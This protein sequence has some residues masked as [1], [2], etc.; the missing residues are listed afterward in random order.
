M[1]PASRLPRAVCFLLSP[2]PHL[3]SPLG[4]YR[5][6]P[7]ALLLACSGDPNRVVLT[8][9]FD[10]YAK[11]AEITGVWTNTGEER[12]FAEATRLKESEVRFQYRLN[13]RN[14]MQDRLYVRL[15]GVQ[16]VGG[17]GFPLGQDTAGIECTLD[18]GTTEGV[19]T[20]SVWLP[21]SKAKK[22]RGFRVSHFAV[23]LNER[24]R[25]LYREWLLKHR[26]D[27]RA[28]IDAEITAYAAAPPCA[29]R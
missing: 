18:A 14:R 10:A 6:L 3:P 21:K 11:L 28:A 19:L 8:A 29:A 22:V 9:P 17:D 15:G 24:G 5:L 20:G 12:A 13:A 2:P 7:V 1:R 26:P 23:P 16:L 25:A 4:W 27:Q